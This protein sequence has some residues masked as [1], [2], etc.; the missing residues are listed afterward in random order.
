VVYGL[1]NTPVALPVITAALADTDGSER[2]ALALL[3]IPAGSVLSDGTRS[4]NV[5]TA[6]TA[7]DLA[8]WNLASLSLRAQSGYTGEI[9]LQVRATS[10][11]ASNGSAV[12][13]TQDITVRV[14][15]GVATATPVGLNPYVTLT[16]STPS[17]TTVA[18]SST[19]QQIVVSSPLVTSTGSLQISVA[20]PVEAGRTWEEEAALDQAREGLLEDA[21]LR[22]LEAAA[23]AQWAHLT[24]GGH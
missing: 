16:G 20:P 8:G 3:G 23:Q 21:W 1:V 13:A 15:G 14:L 5:T 11:E 24:G 2:L 6:G 19:P 9:A 7:V 12:I 4:L 10:T 18:G 17:M 22:E